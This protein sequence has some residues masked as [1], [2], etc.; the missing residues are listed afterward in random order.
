MATP[1]IMKITVTTTTTMSSWCQSDD[2]VE[3]GREGSWTCRSGFP[4]VLPHASRGRHSV[5]IV[6]EPC[7]LESREVA[8]R[9]PHV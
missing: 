4:S 7:A 2:E 9:N 3:R 5:Q 8:V 1:M 6:H